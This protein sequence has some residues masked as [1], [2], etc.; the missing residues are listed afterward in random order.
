MTENKGSKTRITTQHLT[1][2]AII[3][4][5]YVVLS[6]LTYQ[7]SYLEIQ[8]RVAEALCMTIFFTPA[9]AWGVYVGCFITNLFGGSWIDTVFGTMAT[10]IAVLLTLPITKSIRRK[11]GST[12]DIPHSLLI[13]IPTVLVN[14]LIIPFV[15]YYGYGIVSMGSA[16]ARWSVLGLMA[17]SVGAGEIIS[18]YVFGP[19]IVKVMG[20]VEKR[21]NT[22]HG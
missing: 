3:A 21:K 7:F 22:V 10:V 4:G 8:C 12:L 2:G 5:L 17:F 15:L 18:C 1:Q 16:T 20:I 19:I 13:P 14:A 11:C 6:L 9:G